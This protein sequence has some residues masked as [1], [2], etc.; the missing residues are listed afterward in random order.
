MTGAWSATRGKKWQQDKG[1]IVEGHVMKS[2]YLKED[3][4]FFFLKVIDVI[5]DFKV[6]N[7]LR[8]ALQ[9]RKNRVECGKSG[10]R[11]MDDFN[12]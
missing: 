2:L 8:F 6:E 10:D 1:E 12:S 5:K 11:K 4:F 9:F 3:R 7:D